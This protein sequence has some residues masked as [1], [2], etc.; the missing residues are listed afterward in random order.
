MEIHQNQVIDSIILNNQCGAV[1]KL[2]CIYKDGQDGNGIKSKAVTGSFP[3]GQ[4]KEI[5]L[6]TVSELMDL[7]T[8]GREMWVSAFVDVVAGS[9][10]RDKVWFLFKPGCKR[11]AT[12]TITGVINFTS[13]GFNELSDK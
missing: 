10:D 8:A 5:D 1:V 2:R 6:T 7:F 4:S 13:V 9:D 12:F 3:V 11:T